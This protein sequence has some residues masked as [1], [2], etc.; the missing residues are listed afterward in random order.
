MRDLYPKRRKTG[1]PD[2]DDVTAE[3]TKNAGLL[4]METFESDAKDP[5]FHIGVR[6]PSYFFSGSPKIKQSSPAI[7]ETR[8]TSTSSFTQLVNSLAQLRPK[9]YESLIIHEPT[10]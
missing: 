3:S 1:D 7:D 8:F 4:F 10:P 6:I 2:I 9:Q 5:L